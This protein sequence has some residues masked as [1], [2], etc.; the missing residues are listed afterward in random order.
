MNKFI[1][2][3]VMYFITTSLFSQ[4]LSEIYNRV[5]S[6][7]VVIKTINNEGAIESEITK[8]Y[9]NRG[10]GSG[11]LV[12]ETGLIWTASHI[13]HSSEEVVVKFKDGDIYNAEVLSTSPLADVALIKIIGDFEIKNKHIAKIGNSD[14]VLIGEDVFVIGA[15][16]GIEQTL[17]KG[18]ISGRLSPSNLGDEFLPVEYLQTDAAINPGNSGGPLFNMSGEVIGIASFI[19]SKS[20]GFDGIGFGATSNVAKKVL[21]DQNNLWSGIEF[22]I[23]HDD[24]GKAFNLPQNMGLLVLSVSS[25]GLGSKI[26]LQAGKIKAVIDGK[27]INIGGDIILE[28]AGIKIENLEAISEIRKRLIQL[29]KGDTYIVKYF[30]EGQTKIK[31]LMRE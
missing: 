14:D 30:R 22:V 4:N 20:G 6:S 5:N 8:G 10:L 24:L 1:L 7:I 25:K 18:I 2:I 16:L 31:V 26:G 19:L 21:M 9:L 28:I 23:L 3:H 15:P 12:S 11:V 17:S 27:T 13:V 29:K